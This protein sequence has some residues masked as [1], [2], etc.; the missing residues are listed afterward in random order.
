MGGGANAVRVRRG[1]LGWSCL[2]VAALAL[3]PGV[4]TGLP[5]PVAEVEFVAVENAREVPP[6]LVFHEESFESPV[7]DVDMPR[8]PCPNDCMTLPLDQGQIVVNLR[9][10]PE[11]ANQLGFARAIWEPSNEFD[12]E[13][14]TFDENAQATL[15]FSP[16]ADPAT[17]VGIRI[18]ARQAEWE[19]LWRVVP[20]ATL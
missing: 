19:A 12:A 14:L 4:S 5:I 17:G 2:V 11:L 6:A 15:R 20:E 8:R 16:P 18:F 1:S 10:P 3:G 7:N 13:L 9:G